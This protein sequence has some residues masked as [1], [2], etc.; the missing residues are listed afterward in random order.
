[1][2]ALDEIQKEILATTQNSN[3][4]EFTLLDELKFMFS[5]IIIIIIISFAF[6]FG[7]AYV[8]SYRSGGWVSM[9]ETI[10]GLSFGV[11]IISVLLLGMRAVAGGAIFQASAFRCAWTGKPMSD[12]PFEFFRDFSFGIKKDTMA[13]YGSTIVLIVTF[14]LPS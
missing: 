8:W 14:F 9:R 1:M 3:K 4:D 5:R 6:F 7:I 12:K 2:S 10:L 11:T 13:F